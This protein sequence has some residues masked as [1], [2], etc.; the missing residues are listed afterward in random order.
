M[1]KEHSQL[2]EYS[3]NDYSIEP[4]VVVPISFVC[5]SCGNT[6]GH[7]YDGGVMGCSCCKAVWE[8]KGDK[9]VERAPDDF[10]SVEEELWYDCGIDDDFY[11]VEEELW[12]D[13]EIDNEDDLSSENTE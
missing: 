13:Y 12:D 5:P 8:R 10:Y 4:E 3:W 7:V 1:K 6:C 11:R 2:K 9:L